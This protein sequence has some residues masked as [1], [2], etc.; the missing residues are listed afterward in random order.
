MN[1]DFS[2]NTT[3]MIQSDLEIIA[4]FSRPIV[5]VGMMGAGK[6]TMGKALA[7]SLGWDFVDSDEEIVK[8]SGISIAQFFEEKG[9]GSFRTLE[10]EVLETLLKQG[11]SPQ[12]ISTGGGAFAQE[13]TAKVLLQNS[14]CLW[15]DSPVDLLFERTKG[16]DRPLLKN[17][18]PL[19]ALKT[20]S[21]QRQSAY[22]CAQIRF[23]NNY[24]DETI[25]L[26]AM[27][28]DIASYMISHPFAGA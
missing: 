2:F 5:L 25:A 4:K 16:S 9:E 18:D 11:P 6:T 20:V 3:I 22:A 13:E 27:I 10:R 8:T 17:K 26:E 23:K 15:L 21:E 24:T 12:V 14:L 19:E 1:R 7:A 28:K